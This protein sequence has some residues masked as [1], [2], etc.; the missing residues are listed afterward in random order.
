MTRDWSNS[1]ETDPL[2][3]GHDPVDA[4]RGGAV[5]P[6][7]RARAGLHLLIAAARE[8]GGR[9]AGL[10]RA[11]RDA[12]RA[13]RL[14]PGARLPST[15]TLA[16]DLGWA[17]G[18]VAGAYAQLGAE[19]WITARAGAGSVVAAAAGP[20]AAAAAAA[21]EEPEFRHDLRGGNP[22]V[23]AFPRSAWAAALRRVLRDAP[24]TALRIGDPRGRIELRQA[25]AAYLGRVRGV[26]ATPE[27]IVVSSGFIQ[28]LGLVATALRWAGHTELAMEDPCLPHHREVVR[29]A[30]LGVVALA[31]DDGGARVERLDDATAAVVTPAHQIGL[32][33][34]LAPDRRAALAARTQG[35]VLEDDYDGE[36]RYDRQPVGALQA[37]AAGQVV[38]AGTASKSLAPVLRLGWLVLPKPLLDAVVE[39]KRLT[40]QAGPALDQLALAHLIESGEL[41]RHLRRARLRYRRRRD[42]LL[43]AL[44]ARAPRVR[45][46]GIAAGLHVTLALPPGGPSEAELL[47]AARERSLAVTGLARF[48][49]E[50]A[51]RPVHLM[52]GYTTPP[53]H[54]FAGAVDAFA[55]LLGELTGR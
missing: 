26:V 14:P 1:P 35:L 36:F 20:G 8:A 49:H 11:L 43:S 25:L 55:R 18:T 17:R 33:A 44:A 22:D 47:A 30:G 51:D 38:Y 52:V 31:V 40:D 10:E 53:D 34:T 29:A 19:G 4:A 21:P 45:T 37:L 27:R 15:R 48:W 24:D 39:A 54:A 2:G 3:H 28:G 13:G 42:A 6:A 50:P 12:I 41:D 7:G 32:G 23:S 16:A 5:V 9:Q 46:L